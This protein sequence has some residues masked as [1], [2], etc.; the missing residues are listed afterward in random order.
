MNIGLGISGIVIIVLMILLAFVLW[1]VAKLLLIP[2]QILLFL[3]LMVIAYKL[4]FSPESMDKIS[5]KE[6]NEKIQKLVNKASDSAAR[7]VKD[8]AK[9]AVGAQ[10]SA[11]NAPAGAASADQAAASAA[12][13]DKTPETQTK[14]VQQTSEKNGPAE[15]VEAV[16]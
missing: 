11:D 14:T 6:T 9:Q 15:K 16:N 1:R 8:A 7:F 5:D 10:K 12:A 3:I 13:G 4:V 2:I